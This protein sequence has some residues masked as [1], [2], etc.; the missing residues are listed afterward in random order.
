MLCS[1][2]VR[3]L[4]AP[5]WPGEEL[6][7]FFV[8]VQDAL[9]NVPCFMHLDPS[10]RPVMQ[11]VLELSTALAPHGNTNAI[12]YHSFFNYIG[13]TEHNASTRQETENAVYQV[14]QS[15]SRM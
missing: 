1:V 6:C 9:K 12:S 14:R 8:H 13:S 5:K 15:L 3:I 10:C 2:L 11:E 7:F 4:S